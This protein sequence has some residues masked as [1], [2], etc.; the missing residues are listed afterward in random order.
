MV[1][2]T[3]AGS[4]NVPAHIQIVRHSQ[5]CKKLQVSSAKLY[6]MVARGQFPKPFSLVPNGR[7]VGWIEHEVDQ[8]V[9]ERKKSSERGDGS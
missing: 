7:S 8:W 2:V 3:L 9:I 1:Q 6:D 4:P 5:V